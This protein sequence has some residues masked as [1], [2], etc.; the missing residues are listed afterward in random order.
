MCVEREGGWWVVVEGVGVCR[1]R[2]RECVGRDGRRLR[3]WG[4]VWIRR[5]TSSDTDQIAEG[6]C[7]YHHRLQLGGGWQSERDRGG[8]RKRKERRGDREERV[9]SGRETQR[10]GGGGRDTTDNEQRGG[11]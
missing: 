9:D 6:A 10:D 5:A 3:A 1:G 7:H 8:G 4:W 2:G 11:R